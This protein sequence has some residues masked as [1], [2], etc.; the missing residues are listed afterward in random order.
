VVPLKSG[1]SDDIENIVP[2]CK[3]CN[4]RKN[5]KSLLGF[6]MYRTEL[7]RLAA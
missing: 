7:E 3:L 4:S 2:S 6:L 5:T 1:G